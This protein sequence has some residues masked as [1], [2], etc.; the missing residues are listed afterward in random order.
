MLDRLALY[1]GDRASLL[2][3]STLSLLIINYCDVTAAI[4]KPAQQG[5]LNGER[6]YV[7]S[8]RVSLHENAN[9]S[10]GSVVDMNH[11]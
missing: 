2:W 10:F 4:F 11:G 7:V 8:S 5:Q 1:N 6:G 3:T 9:G